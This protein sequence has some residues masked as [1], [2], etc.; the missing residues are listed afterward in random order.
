MNSSKT[1]K[2]ALLALTALPMTLTST[3]LAG[4]EHAH[5]EKAEKPSMDAKA[6]KIW[7]RSVEVTMSENAACCATDSVARCGSNSLTSPRSS[8]A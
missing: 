5:A 4:P 2:I 7:D 6:K 1:L 8:G 3:T